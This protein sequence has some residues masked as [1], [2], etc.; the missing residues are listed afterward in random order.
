MFEKMCFSLFLLVALL[1]G[2]TS[3]RSFVK[4]TLEQYEAAQGIR[5]GGIPNARDLFPYEGRYRWVCPEAT[6]FEWLLPLS[7]VR[8]L[9]VGSELGRVAVITA[10]FGALPCGPALYRQIFEVGLPAVLSVGP[11]SS[12]FDSENTLPAFEQIG[13]ERG[14]FG[15]KPVRQADVPEVVILDSGFEARHQEFQ[16]KVLVGKGNSAIATDTDPL[17]HGTS[18]TSLSSGRQV[19]VSI[20]SRL[21][22]LPVTRQVQADGQNFTATDEVAVVKVLLSLHRR[23]SEDPRWMFVN[24][25]FSV[26]EQPEDKAHWD[27]WGEIFRSF[28]ENK[29]LFV[30]S[31]GNLATDASAFEPCASATNADNV[32]CVAGVDGE[33]RLVGEAKGSGVGSGFGRAVTISAPWTAY[34]AVPEGYAWCTGTSCSAPLVAGA[35]ALAIEENPDTDIKPSALKQ[36]LRR[37]ARFE[38]LEGTTFAGILD[39]ANLVTEVREPSE[40]PEVKV[41]A[42]VIHREGAVSP[43]PGDMV[44]VYGEGLSGVRIYLNQKETKVLY[45]SPSQVI[46]GLPS[47]FGGWKSWENSITLVNTKDGR[48]IPT[49]ATT[50]FSGV[51]LVAP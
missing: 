3:V 22:V 5:I 30:A 36:A 11:R 44:T 45:Q 46:I 23:Y 49:T 14:L 2:Q 20:Q 7:D 12:Q 18:V 39:V 9:P 48:A 29:I 21:S 4:L 38:P 19:G 32:I 50:L 26:Y 47:V 15:Q 43:Q 25:S 1:P 31:A 17:G 34:S 33:D 27:I 13:F 51:T 28:S 40:D 41:S 42:V 24:M 8:L 10:P 37:S 16:G 35:L 6:H